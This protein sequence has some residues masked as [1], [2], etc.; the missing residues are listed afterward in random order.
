MTISR[1]FYRRFTSK[2]ATSQTTP[3]KTDEP[4]TIRLSEKDYTRMK[5]LQF[6]KKNTL[7]G[8]LLLTGVLSVYFYS[9]YAVNQEPLDD[10]LDDARSK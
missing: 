8:L 3:P 4:R 7:V 5:L 2:N 1:S 6:R 10:I 9:M